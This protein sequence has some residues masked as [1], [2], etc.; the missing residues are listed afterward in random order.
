MAHDV[1]KSWSENET[2]CINDVS[3]VLRGQTRCHRHD[4]FTFQSDITAKPG[5]ARA[6]NKFC[7]ANECVHLRPPCVEGILQRVAEQIPT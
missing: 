6:V 5:V 7:V 2:V 1:N 4:A 3:C